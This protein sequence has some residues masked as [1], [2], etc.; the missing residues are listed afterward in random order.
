MAV[1]D[2]GLEARNS[3]TADETIALI[4]AWGESHVQEQLDFVKRNRDIYEAIARG[5]TEQGYNKTWKQCRVK[6][7]NLTQRN[8]KVG[9]LFITSFFI[10]ASDNNNVTGRSRKTCP[11]YDGIDFIIGTR[12]AS[13]PPTIG[14][15][16]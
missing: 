12:A 5:L 10:V 8:R 9:V 1:V 6:I 2:T 16:K 7:K 11:F 4:A 15:L 14:K 3:W 13:H